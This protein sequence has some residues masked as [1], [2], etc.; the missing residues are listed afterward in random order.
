M[1]TLPSF[2]MVL[3]E[4]NRRNTLASFTLPAVTIDIARAKA[5]HYANRYCSGWSRILTSKA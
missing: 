5:R 2:F 1:K 4:D 3:I